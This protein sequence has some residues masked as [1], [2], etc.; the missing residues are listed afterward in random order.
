MMCF[1]ARKETTCTEGRGS[2]CWSS[3]QRI[4]ELVH[5]LPAQLLNIRGNVSFTLAF[6][7]L[8]LQLQ[9]IRS[10]SAMLGQTVSFFPAVF[11]PYI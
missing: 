2:L 4:A 11:S 7:F 6:M 3:L 9:S 8:C 1:P 10:P 5:A